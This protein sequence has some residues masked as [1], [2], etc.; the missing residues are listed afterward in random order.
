MQPGPERTEGAADTA[1]LAARR[2]ERS[3][4]DADPGACGGSRA[5]RHCRR[6]PASARTRQTGTKRREW[7]RRGGTRRVGNSHGRR[8]AL[9][10]RDRHRRHPARRTASRNNSPA[11]PATPAAARTHTPR[12]STRARTD[13]PPAGHRDTHIQTRTDDTD[14]RGRAPVPLP[15]TV[16]GGS[17]GRR[18]RARS[19]TVTG[20]PATAAPQPRGPARPRP[21][22]GTHCGGCG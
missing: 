8:T 3:Q 4:T 7:G 20:Q 12:P 18:G 6:G 21:R 19:L 16:G 17:G 10:L 5:L 2:P 11:R 1:S 9:P 22:P 14:A 15:V 13:T